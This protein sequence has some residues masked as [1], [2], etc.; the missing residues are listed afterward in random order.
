M[1]MITN[2]RKPQNCVIY[3]R[4][5]QAYCCIKGLLARGTKPEQIT[6]VIPGKTCHVMES[7]DDEEEMIKDLEVINP[8]AFD[9]E[10]IEN[11]IHKMLEAKGVRIVRNALLLQI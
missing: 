8:P 9:D 5:L 1:N 7:Y 10:Y 4:T 11:K 6:L 2:R 3:G